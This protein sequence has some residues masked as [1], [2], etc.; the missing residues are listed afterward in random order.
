MTYFVKEPWWLLSLW[1][2]R[3]PHTKWSISQK[4]TVK[5]LRYYSNRNSVLHL[6]ENIIRCIHTSWSLYHIPYSILFVK[7]Y[8]FHSSFFF[9]FSIEKC[10]YFSKKLFLLYR[11]TGYKIFLTFFK[12]FHVNYFMIKI[13]DDDKNIKKRHSKNNKLFFDSLNNL[14]N[15]ND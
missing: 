9:Y 4:K 13:K 14:F 15:Y 7:Y 2:R 5:M 11:S 10:N 3:V 12:K 8:I 6:R 1:R